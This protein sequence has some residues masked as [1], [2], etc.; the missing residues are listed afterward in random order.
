[1]PRPLQ[2]GTVEQVV[3]EMPPWH[4]LDA[5]E[6]FS[7]LRADPN[8]L[9]PDEAARR[10]DEFGLNELPMEEKESALRRFL[11]QFHNTLIYVLLVAAALTAAIGVWVDTGV[12]LGVVIINALIGFI[13]E[14]KAEAAME[15]LREMLSP[16]AVVL[17][18]G[19]AREID[20]REL[21]PGDV[22]LLDSGDRVP[23]DIRI[24][25]SRN[26]QVQ[27]AALTGESNAVSKAPHPVEP[28]AALGDRKS[29]AYSGTLVTG[30]QLRGVVVATGSNTEIGRIGEMISSVKEIKTPFLRRVDAFGRTL[31]L[32]IVLVA[33]AV[34]VL[35]YFLRDIPLT[36]LFLAV[37]SLAVAA[38]P[39]GLPAILTITLALGVQRMARRNAIIRRLPAVETLGS[40]TVICTDKTG[41]LTKN[42]MTVRKVVTA[43]DTYS[44]SGAGYSPEGEFSLGDRHVH[45]HEEPVLLDVL[46]SGLLASDARLRHDESTLGW[47]IEGPPT[48]GAVVVV[49]AKAGLDRR[50]EFD[51]RPRLDEI[52]FESERRFMATLHREPDGSAMIHVKGAPERLLSFCDRQRERDGDK[53]LQRH[54]WEQW[55]NELADTGHRVLAIACKPRRSPEPGLAAEEA[56]SGLTLLGMVGL[57]DP[58]R[59]EAI[60]AIEECRTAGIR[61]KMITGDH[62]LTA[63]SIGAQMGIG[64]GV[65][66]VTGHELEQADDEALVD[67]VRDTDVFARASPEHKL[68]IV[69]A[70]Q[71]VDEVVAMTGDGVNDAPAL[72][73]AD[74]GVAMGIKGSEASKD[75][76]EM[77]LADDNFASI[78]QAVKEGRTIYDNLKK[79]ILFI[80]PTNGAQAL[81]VIAA[82]LLLFEVL[83]VTPVQILWVN[84][85]TAVTLALA[86]AFEPPE[87][88]IMR[89]PPRAPTEQILTP[90]LI[91]RIVF[92]S[93]LLATGALIQFHRAYDAGLPLETA[94]TIG[95][96][97]LVTGQVVYLFN[98]RFIVGSSLS[99]TGLFGNPYAILAALVLLVL[100]L[101]FTYVGIAQTLFGTDAI[102]AEEW[103]AIIIFGVAVFLLVELEKALVRRLRRNAAQV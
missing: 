100:Q 72:K 28:G 60:P 80:L 30:G 74:I 24:F 63:R 89:R 103:I 64:D 49:A 27:E 99:I 20:A 67:I 4:A 45:A 51:E 79:T 52:P 101:T 61:V 69:N 85:V 62:A 3:R 12:I 40:V 41:T 43:N 59:D 81:V 97:T 77:V 35:G 73:R 55:M 84:M 29:M 6:V 86:L 93:I 17:R 18:G 16:R 44:V 15:S 94:R 7:R 78:E 47:T 57:I 68:R 5:E 58:P 23:A 95:I 50:E 53:P 92:I 21:V 11:R 19:E 9:S 56:Q 66:A 42:E 102:P 32:V 71:R 70:L 37:V 1:M 25:R 33:A 13:Q 34:F 36:L 65:T 10:L 75:A 39:E 98:S 2:E 46:R 91:W 8:G 38:I 48:E 83:P 31:S 90:S 14:G 26:G 88:G 96:N 87:P 76:A 54:Y 22:V 82:V